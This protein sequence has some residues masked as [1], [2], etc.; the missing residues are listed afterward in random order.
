MLSEKHLDKIAQGVQAALNK[1][2][3][4]SVNRFRNSSRKWLHWNDSVQIAG[5]S[6]VD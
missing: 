4:G 2:R 6:Q 1:M 3:G 5:E